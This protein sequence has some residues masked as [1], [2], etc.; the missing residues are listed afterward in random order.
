MEMSLSTPFPHQLI[1]S[2]I[3]RGKEL[4]P[5]SETMAT[6]VHTLLLLFFFF[7]IVMEGIFHTR[8]IMD[9]YSLSVSRG[10]L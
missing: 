7:Q 2:D 1:F 4:L 8:K 9:L 10:H 5:S 6:S 3:G